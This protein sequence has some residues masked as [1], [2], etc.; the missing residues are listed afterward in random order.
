MKKLFWSLLFLL[1]IGFT[2]A[3]RTVIP[4][5]VT[6]AD[7]VWTAASGGYV[8]MSQTWSWNTATNWVSTNS[9]NVVKYSTNSITEQYIPSNGGTFA[10]ATRWATNPTD[11]W[12]IDKYF[13]T[14]SAYTDLR[15]GSLNNCVTGSMSV[16]RITTTTWLQGT[17]MTWNNIYILS[18][19][20]NVITAWFTISENKSC[21]AIIS[22]WW[23]V[24]YYSWSLTSITALTSKRGSKNI[25]YDN[26]TINWTWYWDG[27]YH[28]N[29]LDIWITLNP[30]SNYISNATINNIKFNH[31]LNAIKSASTIS[32][33]LLNNIVYANNNMY[34]WGLFIQLWISTWSNNVFIYNNSVYN[35]TR[36]STLTGSMYM[37]LFW[38]HVIKYNIF[39]GSLY[40]VNVVA[41]V[42]SWMDTNV[43]CN[44]ISDWNNTWTNAYW[45]SWLPSSSVVN[46]SPSTGVVW[47]GFLR[48]Q[49]SSLSCQDNYSGTI[50]YSG[51]NVVLCQST[52]SGFDT[53]AT[54]AYL[55]SKNYITWG[56]ET[57]PVWISA[58]GGYVKFWSNTNTWGLAI[59]S[60]FSINADWYSVYSQANNVVYTGKSY[61][62]FYGILGTSIGNWSALYASDRY[63]TTSPQKSTNVAV[64]ERRDLFSWTGFSTWALV[65]LIEPTNGVGI[66]FDIVKWSSRFTIDS[67]GFVYA[68]SGLIVPTVTNQQCITWSLVFSGA[69]FYGCDWA[70][71]KKLDN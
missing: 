69:W 32:P 56:Q 13:G 47:F 16:V 48:L 67:S 17:T 25:I 12:I 65:K 29:N 5:V 33:K 64:F 38:S 14:N 24:V 60:N 58:S 52:A 20:A 7:P 41:W 53:L 28:A 63:G 4:G 55:A 19:W 44:N 27:T 30:F 22:T 51:N 62:A 50:A 21:Y 61:Y 39:T 9:G 3:G 10:D 45:C 57:D 43:F 15:S 1:S 49:G 18:N 36:Y 8:A 2:L 40:A 26:F 59:A 6:E 11:S 54:Q 23:A 46:Y 42:L 71:W 35:P 37:T 66:L 68:N 70:T 34:S 31:V